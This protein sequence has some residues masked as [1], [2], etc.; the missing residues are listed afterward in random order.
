MIVDDPVVVEVEVAPDPVFE[1]L[2]IADD[3]LEV[4]EVGRDDGDDDGLLD[5]K[6]V[7]LVEVDVEAVPLLELEAEL[8][9]LDIF[10]AAHPWKF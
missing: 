8:L 4:V 7:V 10:C 3:D 1:V 2:V 5:D 9:E 6:L